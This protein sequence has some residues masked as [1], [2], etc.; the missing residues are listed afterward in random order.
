MDTAQ[1]RVWWTWSCWYGTHV[2]HVSHSIPTVAVI[3]VRQHG[4]GAVRTKSCL[5]CPGVQLLVVLKVDLMVWRARRGCQKSLCGSCLG[6]AGAKG[7]KH[8]KV[9]VACSSGL[10]W[11]IWVGNVI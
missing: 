4:T 7:T 10:F 1:G 3:N 11:L 5:S 9:P 6:V 2:T 8:C